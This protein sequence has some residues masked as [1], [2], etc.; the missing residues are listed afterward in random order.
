[1]SLGGI[2]IAIGAMVDA[3]IVMVENAH[4][5][6]SEM[7]R[8]KPQRSAARRWCCGAKEVG[9][10]L[11]F[12]LLI[13]TV[14]FLPVFALTGESY[15]LFAPLA[16]TKTYAM[17][18]A[19][20]LSVTR[21]AGLDAVADARAHPAGDGESAQ[22]GCSSGLYRPV[23]RLALQG[24]LGHAGARAR[25]SAS[26]IVP[27]QRTGSEFMPALYE[28]ELLYMP[29]TLPGV[30]ATK[31]REILGQTNRLIK[32]V[33]EVERA[34]GKA[35]RADTATDPALIS[36]IETWVALKPRESSGA[37]ASPSTT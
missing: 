26:I 37:P 4:R 28:G 1:M 33:P 36:M 12:S 7:D 9:P 34:F 8:D 27:L 31:A 13:I 10:G 21:R 15:K 29:T 2:A 20:L 16:F 3:S 17:A 24:A 18:F 35:G 23:L 6:L 14:S 19:A 32:T 5:K 11:F 25:R 22:R 30:S